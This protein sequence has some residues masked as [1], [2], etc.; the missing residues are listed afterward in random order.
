M[1]MTLPPKPRCIP[2]SRH[3]LGAGRQ[4]EWL[5]YLIMSPRQVLIS[6][7]SSSRRLLDDEDVGTIDNLMSKNIATLSTT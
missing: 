5:H 6:N 1:I 4:N 2:H 7:F 3:Y